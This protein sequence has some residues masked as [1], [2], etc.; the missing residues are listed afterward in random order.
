LFVGTFD[1]LFKVDKER[2]S[3]V[4][5]TL[6]NEY[7][8]HILKQSL[9]NSNRIYVGANG[10]WSILKNGNGWIDEGPILKLT[11]QVTSIVE[12]ND[13][14][15]WMG[16]NASGVYRITLRKDGKGEIILHNPIIE[17][18]ETAN[19]LP[20]GLLYVNKFNG[21]D[22]FESLVKYCRNNVGY[23]TLKS[24]I[25]KE[26]GDLMH[27]FFLAETLKYCYLIF[28]PQNTIDFKMTLFNTEAH[29]L[30][31]WK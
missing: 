23:S 19:G 4:R 20:E 15:L 1:G 27:S 9:L 16:T 28:A 17:H 31:V 3:P 7:K 22:Y 21:K 13:G 6:G 10:L 24:V 5:K 18:F 11:D 30:K 25:T 29:P 2:L 12:D 26:Q 8:V 14:K